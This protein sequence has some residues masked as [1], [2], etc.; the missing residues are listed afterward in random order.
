MDRD[1]SQRLADRMTGHLP[2]PVVRIETHGAIVLLSQSRALKLKR[3]VKFSFMDFSTPEKRRQ[4]LAHELELNSRTAQSVYKRLVPVGE[5]G[6]PDGEPFEWALE[7]AR[8]DDSRRLDRLLERGGVSLAML[9]DLAAGIARFHKRLKPLENP[10]QT[11]AMAEVIAGN[12]QDLKA[13]VPAVFSGDSVASL[14]AVTLVALEAQLPLLA[15]RQ[16]WV[17]HCHGDLHSENIVWIG[18]EPVLFDCIEFNDAFAQIDV[19]YDI[20]FLVMDLC[21][22]GFRC[23]AHQIFQAYLEELP[24]DDGLA[25]LPL[26][27]SVRA[28]IRAKVEAFAGHVQK[29]RRY[30]DFAKSALQP[31]RPRLLA[32][33]GLSGTGKTTLARLV[34]PELG[35]LPGAIHLRSDLERKRLFGIPPTQA[36]P[37]DAYKPE[38]GE[39]VFAVLRGRARALLC[40]GQSVVIDMVLAREMERSAL[41]HLADECGVA[42][43]GFWLELPLQERQRRIGCR[44]GDASDA[45]EAVAEMQE[46]YDLG[47]IS[48]PRINVSGTPLDAASLIKKYLQ[49]NP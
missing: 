45:D 38:V 35:R 30:L 16:N 15:S 42:F 3:P 6:R 39:R 31:H 26:F 27:L 4:A 25:L 33:G 44:K 12:A 49:S 20:A 10:L 9:D 1:Q 14:N 7:M 43:Q 47:K 24:Q 34:A 37:K 8:F 5:D 28:A 19:L 32:I 2:Q 23:H 11:E 17:R 22:R 48:W 21:E 40:A 41:E 18:S 29:A 13:S 36:L 46:S